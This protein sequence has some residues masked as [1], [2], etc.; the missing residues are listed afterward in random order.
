[1]YFIFETIEQAEESFRIINENMVRN[2]FEEVGDGTLY[3]VISKISEKPKEFDI[4]KYP[5]LG[6]CKSILV[7]DSGY[8]VTWSI[9]RKDI[10]G[11]WYI[12]KPKDEWC[13]GLNYDKVVKKIELET[14][15]IL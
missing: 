2:R 4:L 11:N 8:T 6:R 9:I 12:P 13:V 7:K 1:M 10:N 15:D 3:N 14:T 5:L